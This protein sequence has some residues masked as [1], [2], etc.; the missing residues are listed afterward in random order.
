MAGRV[1]LEISEGAVKGKEQALR[2]RPGLQLRDG[3]IVIEERDVFIVGRM[4]DCHL[5][6]PESDPLVSRHHF[7]IE[8]APPDANIRDLGS[9]HGTYVDGE[10]YGGRRESETP[11]EAARHAYP[12][13]KLHDGARIQIGGT[14]FV[15]RLEAPNCCEHCGRE[16]PPT[17]QT[18]TVEEGGPLLCGKCR[19]TLPQESR[20][21]HGPSA[22]VRCRECGRPAPPGTPVRKGGWHCPRCQE[23]TA[24][25]GSRRDRRRT[26]GIEW[27]ADEPEIRGYA[28][29]RVLGRGGF[30]TVYEARRQCDGQQVA[31][32]IMRARVAVGERARWGFLREIENTSRLRHPQIVRLL[33]HGTTAGVFFFV[34][35]FCAGGSLWE[36][37][38]RRGGR[39]PLA[40]AGEVLVDA[41]KGLAYIHEQGIVHRDLKPQNLLLA[42]A[43]GN[44]T[45]KVADLGLA[46]DFE[47]AGL[48][49]MT[50]TGQFAGTFEFMPR[51][52][53]TNYRFMKPSSDVWSMGA[54]FYHMLTGKLPHNFVPGRDKASILLEEDTVPIQEREPTIPPP[55]ARFLDRA[56]ATKPEQRFQHAGEMLEALQAARSQGGNV[57]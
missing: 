46:K 4:P 45:T 31:V 27:E 20:S 9:L 39:L 55:I 34:M 1:I 22:Q 28:L 15:V 56:L 44:W 42:A 21:G 47:R 7:L 33:E 10:K 52:H 53:L 29:G 18:P 38:K 19:G 3:K 6:L 57:R 32:K 16:I 17:E 30:G 35:E 13:I 48:S 5:R 37:I 8:C 41:L 25:A 26:P 36:L 50:L 51:E 40:E 43:A 12:T 11:E 24:P 54:T 49:G 23:T 14:G 2:L